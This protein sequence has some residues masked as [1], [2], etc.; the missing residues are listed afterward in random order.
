M[1]KKGDVVMRTTPAPKIYAFDPMDLG[2]VGVVVE[3]F[4][5][6]TIIEDGC[7]NGDQVGIRT[8]ELEK[9]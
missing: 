8:E 6:F 4:G 7:K 5:P 2:A 1:F 3:Q 9:I